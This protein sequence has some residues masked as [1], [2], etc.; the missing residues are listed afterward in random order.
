MTLYPLW[1]VYSSHECHSGGYPLRQVRT[2]NQWF[3]LVRTELELGLIFK[4]GVEFYRALPPP[5]GQGLLHSIQLLEVL[6][7]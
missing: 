6:P 4:T 5:Q 2:K 7:Y 1:Q 3:Q